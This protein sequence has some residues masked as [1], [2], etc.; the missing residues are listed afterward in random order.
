MTQEELKVA[1][2]RDVMRIIYTYPVKAASPFAHGDSPGPP[3]SAIMSKR[4]EQKR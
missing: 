2:Q 3:A 4:G 1:E